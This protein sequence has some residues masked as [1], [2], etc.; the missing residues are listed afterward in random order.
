LV[1]AERRTPGGRPS[2]VP[3]N[4]RR[5]APQGSG[6]VRGGVLLVVVAFGLVRGAIPER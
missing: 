6:R 1:G 3:A 2:A 5:S 4:T